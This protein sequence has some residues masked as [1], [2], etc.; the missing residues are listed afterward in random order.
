V[1]SIFENVLSYFVGGEEVQRALLQK[2]LQAEL[3]SISVSG[4]LCISDYIHSVYS[5]AMAIGMS[6]EVP[7]SELWRLY[8]SCGEN[9]L[10]AFQRNSD[11]RYFKKPLSELL[12]YRDLVVL[13]KWD[14]EMKEL[15]CRMKCSVRHQL[16]WIIQE[17]RCWSF[18]FWYKSCFCKETDWKF[19]DAIPKGQPARA[20]SF[21]TSKA[22]PP[23]RFSFGAPPRA[24]V[25]APIGFS[26]GTPTPFLPPAPPN[27]LLVLQHL[28]HRMLVVQGLLLIG[29]GTVVVSVIVIPI[30]F[31][32]YLSHGYWDR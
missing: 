7:K 27:F 5:K 29:T 30:C 24:P 22:P 6:I 32:F 21:G 14:G 1:I 25:S 13:L 4:Y 18:P 16:C 2:Q 28:V 12:K 3:G 31:L 23:P 9:S 20:F 8:S 17:K 26:V 10:C 19:V 11:P 15:S